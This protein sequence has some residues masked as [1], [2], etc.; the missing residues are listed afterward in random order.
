MSAM[1]ILALC[2]AATA[3]DELP[4]SET[5]LTILIA[6]KGQL[7]F[8]KD[9]VAFTVQI[10]SNKE[11]PKKLTLRCTLTDLWGAEAVRKVC[12]ADLTQARTAKVPISFGRVP[13]GYYTLEAALLDDEKVI[14]Q[15]GTTLGV[16]AQIPSRSAASCPLGVCLYYH[17]E[18]EPTARTGIKWVR[19]DF[20]WPHSEWEPDKYVWTVFD[21][22]VK[23]ATALDLSISAVLLQTPAWASSAPQ[24]ISLDSKFTPQ[25][26]SSY[27]DYYWTY[28]PK[29]M[30]DWREF[31]DTV[32]KRYH[33]LIKY[34]EI[35]NE[36]DFIF[37]WG[38]YEQYAE[39]LKVGYQAIKKVD[40]DAQVLIAG[41]AWIGGLRVAD[42]VFDSPTWLKTCLQGD[43]KNCFDILNYHSYGDIGLLLGK[44]AQVRQ[45]AAA[46]GCQKP[47]WCTETG[48]NS[49]GTP[50]GEL[51]QCEFLV[52]ACVSLLAAEVPRM[53]W[54][55]LRDD[56]IQFYP[57]S[58]LFRKDYSPKPSAVA[59]NTLLSVID[60]ATFVQ[61]IRRSNDVVEYYF[62]K[63]K[64]NIAV[65]WRDGLPAN[66][67]ILIG[68]SKPVE[69]IDIVGRRETLTPSGNRITFAVSRL[70]VFLIGVPE[71]SREAPNLVTPELPVFN[72]FVGEPAPISLNVADV[73][74]QPIE[75]RLRLRAPESWKIE[76]AERFF[77]LAPTNRQVLQYNALAPVDFEARFQKLTA[78]TVVSKETL[79]E[80]STP[81]L[82]K[83]LHPLSLR[84]QPLAGRIAAG[85]KLVLR[86]RNQTRRADMGT[87]SART[88]DGWTL[89]TTEVEYPPVEPFKE[90]QVVLTVKDVKPG[91]RA[92]D[93]YITLSAAG[94]TGKTTVQRKLP[95]DFAVCTRTTLPV[96]VDGDLAEWQNALPMHLGSLEQASRG[97]HPLDW[98]GPEDL[99]VVLYTM[100]DDDNLYVAAKARDDIL[101]CEVSGDD[102][103]QGD[104]FQFALDTGNERGDWLD[105]NDYEFLMGLTR[106]GPYHWVAYA[107]EGKRR[108]DNPAVKLAI[109][110]ADPQNLL[111]EIAVPFAE[112]AP[113]KPKPG[114]I[115]GFSALYVD[116]DGYGKR[117]WLSWFDGIG[118]KKCPK[119]Y[120]DLV[121]IE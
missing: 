20:P 78:E 85:T 32:L 43:G 74:D 55:E 37:W 59:A 24:G 101:S 63:D 52:K 92:E 109:R 117:G 106:G 14:T 51:R 15:S 41:P 47:V 22:W 50:Q 87:I 70:P 69:L 104:S 116:N 91:L 54:W 28:P 53:F 121:F 77:D 72:L 31:V 4:L 42:R 76:P 64:T 114:T 66:H 113:F 118:D 111:Y 9:P 35:W 46:E 81:V 79:G 7:F 105:N 65:V 82:T 71:L 102:I 103:W 83:V 33:R 3:A 11:Y 119:D 95:L 6:E 112:L 2:R 13:R 40:P 107:P 115:I 29:D 108:R 86:I 62:S 23:E 93:M 58:G 34:W 1:S 39:L 96:K 94:L 17:D 61:S 110:R 56:P 80:M 49:F 67:S 57:T 27:K 89:A 60:G 45:I 5:A 12:E 75:G 90:E 73:L 38:T 98:R 48:S 36:S 88:S 30:E 8:D 68:T 44:V 21:P 120:G 19:L 26:L 25:S 99:S 16:V 18:L 97:V 100:W 10:G 84:L